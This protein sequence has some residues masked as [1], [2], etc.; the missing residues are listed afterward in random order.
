MSEHAGVYAVYFLY[1]SRYA[2][3]SGHSLENDEHNVTL[4]GLEKALLFM[5]EADAYVL[6]NGNCSRLSAKCIMSANCRLMKF[7]SVVRRFTMCAVHLTIMVL[8]D[9]MTR[10]KDYYVTR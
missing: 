8:H 2:F 6:S 10:R 3:V 1:R 7:C 4:S 9:Q 5:S